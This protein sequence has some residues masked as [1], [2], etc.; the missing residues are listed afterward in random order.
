MAALRILGTFIVALGIIRSSRAQNYELMENPKAGDCRQIQLEMH[1]SGEMRVTKDSKP[2]PLKM[3]ADASHAFTERVLVC[4]SNAIVQKAARVYEAAKATIS[5]G[6]DRY[7]KTLRSERRLLVA[8]HQ[9]G[10]TIVYSPAGP[11][12]KEE[13][14]LTSEH[15][16]TLTLAGLLPGRPVKIGDSWKVA[17]EVTQ[18]LCHFEGLTSQDLTCKL[19]EVKDNAARISFAGSAAGIDLGA[20]AKVTIQGT[21]RFDRATKNLVALEWKQKDERDQGPASPATTVELTIQLKRNPI[22][23]PES[24]S[25]VGLISV[26]DG[27]DIPPT[28]LNLVYQHADKARFELSYPRDWQ[29]VGR[30]RDHVV[31]RLLDRGDFVAQLTI[32]P[33]DKAHNT[34]HMAPEEFKEAMSQSPGWEQGDVVQEGEIP[35]ENG[36]WIY[37]VSAPGTM[38]GINV[39]QNFYLV[40]GPGGVQIVMAFTMT[41]NQAEKLGT[42]DL[43]MVRGLEFKK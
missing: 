12:T 24:L 25:D 5:I 2:M 33:W 36:R 20:L 13:L 35:A 14:E 18:A 29:P 7:K 37:R 10:Q 28:L 3:A 31:F 16:D 42:R 27:L 41:P 38:D 40:A 26:P 34:A 11:L 6:E 8:Q 1:L 43:V 4:G 19:E 30:I 22:E 17:N 15:F 32:T 23:Q 9:E 21:Y 39:V